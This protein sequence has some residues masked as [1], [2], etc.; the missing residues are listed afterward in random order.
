MLW[1]K[2]EV[3]NG[4]L[5]ITESK[6]VD[7]SS[8]TSD[9]WPV[10]IEGLKACETCKLLG[11]RNCGGKAIRAKL[12]PQTPIKFKFLVGDVNWKNHGGSWISTTSIDYQGT[13]A[14]LVLNLTN[15][16]DA[17][18]DTSEGRYL[19]SLSAVSPG[20][21]GPE[22]IKKALQS[23]QD[24]S[25]IEDVSDEM[26]VEA[27]NSYGVEARLWYDQGNNADKLLAE[28]RRQAQLGWLSLEQKLN[29][30]QNQ[31][32]DTGHDVIRGNLLTHFQ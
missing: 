5:T 12:L 6:V 16:E 3:K 32:G 17:C 15:M 30:P 22:N 23:F 10:Q 4:Q 29:R 2:G 13:K 25:K 24:D 19:V 18:G 20:A 11:K 1:E 28:G 8:L 31:V 7:Q 27:L 26:K 14:W 21:A 9:C